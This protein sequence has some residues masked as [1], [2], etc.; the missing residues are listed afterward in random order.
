MP[1]LKQAPATTT[2]GNK[3]KA[4]ADKAEAE[5]SSA[6]V[7]TTQNGSFVVYGV[8]SMP[9]TSH[10]N[11]TAVVNGTSVS[12]STLATVDW[13]TP[14]YTLMIDPGY[15]DGKVSCS[16]QSVCDYCCC[17]CSANRPATTT[18]IHPPPKTAGTTCLGQV[19]VVA[20]NH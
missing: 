5:L 7:L 1:S 9:G 12:V 13:I 18:W 2:P 20:C 17:Q 4:A 19:T 11:A 14:K 10:Y 16:L 6:S 15:T 8:S 3:F